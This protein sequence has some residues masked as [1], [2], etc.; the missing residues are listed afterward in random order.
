MKDG[1]FI[2]GLKEEVEKMKSKGKKQAKQIVGVACIAAVAYGMGVKKGH[3]TG[4]I[5]G[6]LE[7]YVS[8]AE[9][10]ANVLKDLKR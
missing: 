10:I 2:T 7:G 3:K 9:D 8:G 1:K 6:G 4:F 5:K